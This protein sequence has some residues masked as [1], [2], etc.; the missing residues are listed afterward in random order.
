MKIEIIVGDIDILVREHLRVAIHK[1]V[2][3]YIE[4][5]VK[6]IFVEIKFKEHVCSPNSVSYI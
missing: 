2:E 4:K 1:N 6:H 5:F 3:K